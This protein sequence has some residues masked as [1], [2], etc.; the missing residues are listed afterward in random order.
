M[1]FLSKRFA[2]SSSARATVFITTELFLQ[3]RQWSLFYS[4]ESRGS[5][6]AA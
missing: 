2:V 3:P 5:F 4:G 1:P 6:M